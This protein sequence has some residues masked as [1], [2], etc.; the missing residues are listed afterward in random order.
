MLLSLH[1]IDLAVIAVYLVGCTALGAKIGG[2]SASTGL[3]GY[4]L[5]ESNI[6]AWAV[7]ISIVATETSA[8]TF[9]SVPGNAYRGDFTFLQLA[10]GYILARVAVAALLLPSYFK[11]EIFTAYQLLQVRFGVSTQR[12]A[13]V[14]FL[15]TRTLGAGLRLFL[16]ANVLV[17]I[18][19]WDVRLS[20]VVIGVST[21][22]YT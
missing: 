3:K 19:G 2:G 16:A 11:G 21:L 13:S 5:G 15:V 17:V 12:A 9:L 1:W 18:T 10:F 6:P 22:L 14:L 4:F 7:M 20:I 8:V